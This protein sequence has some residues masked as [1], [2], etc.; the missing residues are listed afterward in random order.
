LSIL[1]KLADRVDGVWIFEYKR[2]DFDLED[3][4]HGS[5]S[6]LSHPDT[7]HEISLIIG[8]KKVFEPR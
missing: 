2:N 3:F 8:K 1:L 4:V 6:E 5:W 7:L